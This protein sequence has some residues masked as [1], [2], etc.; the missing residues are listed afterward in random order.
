MRKPNPPAEVIQWRKQV[1]EYHLLQAPQ[2]CHTCD[3]YTDDGQ[4]SF[5]QMTPPEDFASAIG[6]CPEWMEV[7][8]F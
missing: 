8:P 2:C 6:Q 5:Y 1:E 7:L 4:C 3:N